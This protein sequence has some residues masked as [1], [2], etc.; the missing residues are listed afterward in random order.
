[1]LSVTAKKAI[2]ASGGVAL[3]QNS[4]Y[5]EAE[6]SVKGLAFNLKRRPYFEHAKIVM[7][8]GRPFSKLTPIGKNK[9]IS[10][11]LNGHNVWLEDENGKII[12]ER[13]NARDFFPFGRR[14]FYWDDLDM[15][16]FANYAFWNYFTFPNLLMNT[17]I[18]WK[19]KEE[20]VLEATF[21]ST[22]PTHST[23]QEF[24]IDILSGKLIQ[25]NY[26]ADIISKL[27]KAANV[28]IEHTE[29]N[30]LLYP[31]AR[32]VTPRTGKG[33]ALKGPVLIDIKIHKFRLTNEEIMGITKTKGHTI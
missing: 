26:T 33:K 18:I 8:I 1:M 20:G 4:K 30:G 13:K 16:Y 29:K 10:G 19:E 12:S 32:L 24:H 5:L 17:N 27:A 31:S 28:I 3:W 7:E 14:L 25:H 23:T 6:V 2:E 11:V 15:A 9:N 22:I 21:P